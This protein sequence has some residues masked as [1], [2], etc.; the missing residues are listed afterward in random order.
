MLRTAHGFYGDTYLECALWHQMCE[1][2]ISET[3]LT[4]KTHNRCSNVAYI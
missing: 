1:L 2:L 3:L 4:R